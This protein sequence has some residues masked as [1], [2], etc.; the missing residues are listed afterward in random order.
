MGE[1]GK[2]IYEFAATREWVRVVAPY[3]KFLANTLKTIVPLVTPAVDIVFGV[4]TTERLGIG[5]HLSL[6]EGLAS[7]LPS[8]IK[9]ADPERLQ[10]DMLSEDE[11][12]GLLALHA[13]LKELD[14][15]HKK[16]GLRRTL[17]YT[18]DFAWVCKKHY[19]L[20]QPKIPE[21]I[22]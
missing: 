1:K 11:R 14:P 12:S 20:M 5:D 17:T 8:D 21:K 22:V 16:I 13:L 4:K 10:Q 6:M 2:G 9:V 7:N 15:Q 18:G 19:D 3:A